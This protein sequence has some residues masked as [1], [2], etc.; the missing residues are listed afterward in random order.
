MKL[1]SVRKPLVREG[2][3]WTCGSHVCSFSY[4]RPSLALPP[5]KAW[6]R[7]KSKTNEK[8]NAKTERKRDF[9]GR[10]KLKKDDLILAWSL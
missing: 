7:N 10:V 8:K 6:R 1:E 5:E 4:P 9:K 3:Q 2:G